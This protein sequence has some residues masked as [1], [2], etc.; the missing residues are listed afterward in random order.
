MARTADGV[1]QVS[2]KSDFLEL[3]GFGV[4]VWG[5]AN[6]AP[7][8]PEMFQNHVDRGV[9]QTAGDQNKHRGAEQGRLENM[10]RV[11]APTGYSDT[12]CL[13][14][15]PARAQLGN[16]ESLRQSLTQAIAVL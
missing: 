14:D 12:P 11:H 7:L 5:S 1:E 16:T 9:S 10:T 15:L 8:L 2:V 13:C 4:G 6:G 3:E